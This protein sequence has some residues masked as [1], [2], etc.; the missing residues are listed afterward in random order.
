MFFYSNT[1]LKLTPKFA[2]VHT[3]MKYPT[4]KINFQRKKKKPQIPCLPEVYSNCKTVFVNSSTGWRETLYWDSNAN[5][6]KK[7]TQ[8]P[9]K[10][11]EGLKQ[12]E[13]GSRS[14]YKTIRSRTTYEYQSLTQYNAIK[15]QVWKASRHCSIWNHYEFELKKIINTRK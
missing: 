1:K 3:H 12:R 10:S 2:Y 9:C 6:R 8:M 13:L 7:V 4:S 15:T 14:V 11:V 5:W